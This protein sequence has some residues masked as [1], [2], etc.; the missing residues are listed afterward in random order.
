MKPRLGPLLALLLAVGACGRD[1]AT[2]TAGPISLAGRGLQTAWWQK[3]PDPV[4]PVLQAQPVTLEIPGDALFA[5]GSAEVRPA[6]RPRLDTFAANL[7]QVLASTTGTWAV[8]GATDST[9]HANEALGLARAKAVASIIEQAAP[10]ARGRLRTASWGE[11]C[12]A[13][14]ETDA[15]DLAQA[16]AQNRRVV[17]V[18]PAATP[19]CP[20]P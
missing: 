16:R 6:D 4:L 19:P 18:P 11:K 5:T 20:L 12:P 13:V 7:N 17:I 14:D 2:T 15:S 3:L 10:A 8:A 9:G 1:S